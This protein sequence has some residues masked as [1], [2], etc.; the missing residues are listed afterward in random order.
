MNTK[1][2]Q[3]VLFTNICDDTKF[4]H[5][6]PWFPRSYHPNTKQ[7]MSKPSQA[8]V[9]TEGGDLHKAQVNI[10]LSVSHSCIWLHHQTL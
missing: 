9:L 2:C 1:L 4:P 5:T 8:K 6:C 10:P 7:L 3:S